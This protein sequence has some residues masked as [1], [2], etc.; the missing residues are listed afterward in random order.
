[1]TK[2]ILTVYCLLIF[3]SV[4]IAQNQ[5]Q[6]IAVKKIDVQLSQAPTYTVNGQTLPSGQPHSDSTKKWLV[7]QAE[8][9]CE[10]ES[11]DDVQVKFYV[12]AQYGGGSKEYD[13]L[14][15]TVNV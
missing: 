1:M 6:E 14:A 8:L 12:V 4:S 10:A 3:V 9:E 7:I 13:I 11:A 15:T 5:K 2:S